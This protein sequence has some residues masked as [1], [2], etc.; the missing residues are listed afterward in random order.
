MIARA[1]E[2][3]EVHAQHLTRA[4]PCCACTHETPL[5]WLSYMARVRESRWVQWLRLDGLLRCMPAYQN[6]HVRTQDEHGIQ[7]PEYCTECTVSGP[8]RVMDD[9][10]VSMQLLIRT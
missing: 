3:H 4:P 10:L 6:A 9:A 1:M 7:S 2:S 8:V 5:P